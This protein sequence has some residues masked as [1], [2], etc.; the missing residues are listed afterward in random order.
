MAKQRLSKLQRWILIECGKTINGRRELFENGFLF[1]Q[2]ITFGYFKEHSLKAEV[3][4]S[5]SLRNLIEKGLIT[6][7][8]PRIV[9]IKDPMEILRGKKM[10]HL[11]LLSALSHRQNKT[12]DEYA[13]I[14]EEFLKDHKKGDVVISPCFLKSDTIKLLTLTKSG[15]ATALLLS[16]DKKVRL[17]NKKKVDS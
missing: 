10:D 6:G 13:K 14:Q 11:S 5:R 2:E 12:L 7:F 17:N 1:R 4:V 9:S 16:I 8:T 3:S 15:L